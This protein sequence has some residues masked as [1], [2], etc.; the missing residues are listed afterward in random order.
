MPAFFLRAI[1]TANKKAGIFFTSA[2]NGKMARFSI[3]TG[4]KDQYL[5]NS[6][7]FLTLGQMWVIQT[8][9][10]CLSGRAGNIQF[11]KVR[12]FRGAR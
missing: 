4:F 6:T 11:A 9:I 7:F 2:P 1:G 12:E 3:I 5:S 10:P 8:A